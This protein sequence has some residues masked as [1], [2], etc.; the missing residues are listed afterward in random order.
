MAEALV[1]LLELLYL[2][3]ASLLSQLV[4]T[5]E[6]WMKKLHDLNCHCL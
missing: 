1:Q 3:T 2:L 4:A 5:P 6:E